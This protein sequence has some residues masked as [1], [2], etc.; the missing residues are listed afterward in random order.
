MRTE[1]SARLMQCS[2]SCG[3]PL[4]PY[5]APFRH[6]DADAYLSQQAG[7]RAHRESVAVR[8]V[9]VVDSGAQIRRSGR[10]LATALLGEWDGPAH[11]A[12]PPDIRNLDCRDGSALIWIRC[13]KRADFRRR[14][15]GNQAPRDF[16]PE[17]RFVDML[18]GR[19]SAIGR[20][21]SVWR[22]GMNSRRWTRGGARDG[23]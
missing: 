19:G 6:A 15:I 7:L 11:A 22:S 18:G 9:S 16:Q 14:V 17:S 13:Y 1:C 8:E 20:A 2:R 5:Q 4:D 10:A 21:R 23:H 3:A 12:S